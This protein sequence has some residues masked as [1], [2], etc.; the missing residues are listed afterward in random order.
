[1]KRDL[2][3]L[4]RRAKEYGKI[5]FNDGDILVAEAG[6]IDKRTVIDK[7]TGLHIVKPVTFEDG[8]Y[9]YICPECGEIHSIHKSRVSRNKPIKKGCCKARSH[10]N[11]SCWING[12]H[13]KIKTSKIILDY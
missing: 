11:R 8:Y 5:M 12:K 1:M 7:S 4:V 2:K 9:N 6:Y 10:S 3:D 13:L